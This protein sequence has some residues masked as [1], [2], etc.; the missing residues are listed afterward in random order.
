MRTNVVKTYSELLQLRTFDE[1]FEYLKLHG[2]VGY[3]TFGFDRIFNQMF[4]H[5]EDWKLVK[6]DIIIRDCGYDLGVIDEE[7]KIPD[8]QPIIIHHM[9][10]IDIEDIR[11]NTEYLL[12]PEFLISCSDLTHKAIHYGTIDTARATHYTERTL[13][14]TC[15]WRK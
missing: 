2:R 15:P 11:E 3:D 5:S 8:K 7:F 6:R 14:D 4:Y 9:N 10:P 1:R 12:N 13:N